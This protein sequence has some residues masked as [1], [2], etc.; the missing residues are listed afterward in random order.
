MAVLKC[1]LAG[2]LLYAAGFV[3]VKPPYSP[4]ARTIAAVELAYAL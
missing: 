1:R 4:P 3:L 2:R